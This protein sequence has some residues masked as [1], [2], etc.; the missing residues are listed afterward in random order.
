MTSKQRLH[1]II[2]QLPD[3]QLNGI[4]RFLTDPSLAWMFSA[5]EGEPPLSME[6]MA[7]IIEGKRQAREGRTYRFKSVDDAIAWLENG[8]E[9]ED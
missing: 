4:E 7:G 1:E 6:E 9:P 5:P 8:P 3:D 2:E